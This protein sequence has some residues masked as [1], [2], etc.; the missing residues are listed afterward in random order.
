MAPCGFLCHLGMGWLPEAGSEYAVI[1]VQPIGPV[2]LQRETRI[3]P[4]PG[5]VRWAKWGDRNSIGAAVGRLCCRSLSSWTWS[6][7][8]AVPVRICERTSLRVKGSGV[9]VWLVGLIRKCMKSNHCMDRR[10]TWIGVYGV[11]VFRCQTS[12]VLVPGCLRGGSSDSSLLVIKKGVA[13]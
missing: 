5:R 1:A 6:F 9:C 2:C 3:C 4:P 8:L 13:T 11:L 7:L 12:G 10:R